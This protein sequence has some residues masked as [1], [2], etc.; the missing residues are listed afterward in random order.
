MHF[1]IVSPTQN[2]KDCLSYE[3]HYPLAPGFVLRRSR[4]IYGST[5]GGGKAAVNLQSAVKSSSATLL[6]YSPAAV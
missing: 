2:L 6:R 5:S 4:T 1:R 3:H